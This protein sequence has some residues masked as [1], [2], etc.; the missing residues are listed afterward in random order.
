MSPLQS[1]SRNKP[2][3]LRREA[4]ESFLGLESRS[5]L[6]SPGVPS[7]LFVHHNCLETCGSFDYC[8]YHQR[9]LKEV[10]PGC[11]GDWP[12]SR[13]HPG[14]APGGQR[15]ALQARTAERGQGSRPRGQAGGTS[16]LRRPPRR[17][18]AC[19][20][21]VS[22]LQR[23]GGTRPRSCGPEKPPSGGWNCA[24]A[25]G[26][27]GQTQALGQLEKP[28]VFR[29]IT[30]SFPRKACRDHSVLV[31]STRAGPQRTGFASAASLAS[32]TSPFTNTP[33]R[34]GCGPPVGASVRD[35]LLP[36]KAATGPV[37]VS[38]Q[39]ACKSCGL[40]C[41][42]RGSECPGRGLSPNLLGGT[43]RT[44]T[45]AKWGELASLPRGWTAGPEQTSPAARARVQTAVTVPSV[46]PP[47]I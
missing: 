25:P 10:S 36:G 23:R 28:Q 8:N 3:E 24:G 13:Y 39:E 41:W 2:S 37:R 43:L 5:S 35:S 44:G 47:W 38:E 32:E 27:R 20:L 21:Q 31:L 4:S 12:G 19:G 17:D 40:G 9:L 6:P 18:Q 22:Q 26:F 1:S 14:G 30:L 42:Q 29:M 33:N 15:S 34:G 46:F 11:R 45:R 7:G 16:P